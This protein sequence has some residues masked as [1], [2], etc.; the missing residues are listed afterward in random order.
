[1]V[2][3]FVFIKTSEHV[4]LHQDSK[5]IFQSALNLRVLMHKINTCYRYRRYIYIAI[6]NR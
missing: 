2:F 5:R 3:E 1:M 4:A 6:N